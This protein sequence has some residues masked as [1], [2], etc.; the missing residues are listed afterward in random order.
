MCIRDRAKGDQTGNIES[1][2]GESLVSDI[3]GNNNSAQDFITVTQKKTLDKS[4]W[5]PGRVTLPSG[6]VFV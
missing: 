5:W 6:F 2:K 4:S 3:S 1:M